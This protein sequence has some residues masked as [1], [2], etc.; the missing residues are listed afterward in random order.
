M[1]YCIMNELPL[2]VKVAEKATKV[3]GIPVIDCF[4]GRKRVPFAIKKHN[5]GADK[6]L[7]YLLNAKIVITDSFHAVA[8]C[9]NNNKP[10]YVIISRNGNR[11]ISILELFG[12]QDRLITREEDVDFTKEIDWEPVNKKLEEVRK[13]NQDWLRN[14]IFKAFEDN[15]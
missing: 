15:K 13:E 12:L 3:L 1:E 11:I 14:S 5:V 2:L 8:F 6:W 4:G 7:G 9:I 10:F